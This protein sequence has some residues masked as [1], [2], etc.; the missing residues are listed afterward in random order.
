[1]NQTPGYYKHPSGIT[2]ADI[3]KY[4]S[5][6]L[7]QAF[8]YV[9]RAGNKPD[10]DLIQD[11]NK[12]LDWIDIELTIE[13]KHAAIVKNTPVNALALSQVLVHETGNKAQALSYI[14]YANI[15]NRDENLT[16]AKIAIQKM[17]DKVI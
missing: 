12:A 8:Q 17:I 13:P 7:A 16:A 4:L 1:M 5:G 15:L 3:S 2:A 9:W 10:N 6:G 14:F 11:L